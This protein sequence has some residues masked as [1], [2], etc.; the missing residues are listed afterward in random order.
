MRD[1]P[2][3]PIWPSRSRIYNRVRDYRAHTWV[4]KEKLLNVRFGLLQLKGPS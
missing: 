2:A 4:G 3:E 1:R